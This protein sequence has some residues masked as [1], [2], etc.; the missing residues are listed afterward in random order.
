VDPGLVTK[1]RQGDEDAFAEIVVRS[2]A[3]LNVIARAVLRDPQAAEDAVQEALVGAWRDLPRLRDVDRFEQ[4]LR[5]LLLRACFDRARQDR[6]V[7]VREIP[8][9][10]DSGSG[11]D[12]PAAI[13][14]RDEVERAL[15]AL[16]IEHRAVLVLTYYLDLPLAE[17]AEVLDIP[18]GT[19]KSRLDRA[20]S[21]MRAALDAQDR[22]VV[23][24]REQMA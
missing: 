4:W 11:D 15:A 14:L 17:A 6:K 9:V 19:M 18:V 16:S 23:A 8:G 22:V 13:L 2:I 3:R 7:R 20:R 5:R 24:R 21:A 12:H 10:P 1:A